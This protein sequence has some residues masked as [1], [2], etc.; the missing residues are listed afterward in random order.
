MQSKRKTATIKFLHTEIDRQKLTEINDNGYFKKVLSAKSNTLY[1]LFNK[2]LKL[3]GK[4]NH[5][6]HKLLSAHIHKWEA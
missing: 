2:A 6:K 3:K 5:I 1:Q 4:K